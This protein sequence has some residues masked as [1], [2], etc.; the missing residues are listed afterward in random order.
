MRYTG[1]ADGART[2]PGRRDE[3]TAEAGPFEREDLR[4]A[5]LTSSRYE[6][7]FWE[8]AYRMETWPV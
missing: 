6:Y 3:T 2:P 7:A 1:R 8:M 4:E 5:F